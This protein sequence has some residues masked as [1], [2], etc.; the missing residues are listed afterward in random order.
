M[1]ILTKQETR[2]ISYA[3]R[4]FEEMADNIGRNTRMGKRME[5]A[6]D[7]AKGILEENIRFSRGIGTQGSN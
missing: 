3:M 6:S 4:M 1:R 5:K 7:E 2:E